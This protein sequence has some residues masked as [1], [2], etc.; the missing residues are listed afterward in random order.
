MKK[1]YSLVMIVLVM[2]L[3]ACGKPASRMVD[4][5]AGMTKEQVILAL[6]NPSSVE[7]NN[8]KEYLYYAM[9]ELPLDVFT[10]RYAVVLVDGRVV[11]YGREGYGEE[12][13]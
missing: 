4:I 10:H 3:L 1:L 2:S 8:G 6:G 12:D 9:Y 13:W 11:S 7:L 5:T